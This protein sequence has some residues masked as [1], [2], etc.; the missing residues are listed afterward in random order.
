MIQYSIC[1]YRSN[2][3]SMYGIRII[4]SNYTDNFRIAIMPRAPRLSPQE[5]TIVDE[6]LARGERIAAILR[7]LNKG[8]SGRGGRGRALIAK[9]RDNRDEYRQ[10]LGP[11]SGGQRLASGP[12]RRGPAKTILACQSGTEGEDGAMAAFARSNG[13]EF[14]IYSPPFESCQCEAGAKGVKTCQTSVCENFLEGRKCELNCCTRLCENGATMSFLGPQLG[15]G[16]DRQFGKTLQAME[17]IS[18]GKLLGYY[19]GDLKRITQDALKSYDGEYLMLVCAANKMPD[20]NNGALYLDAKQRGSLM[21]FASHS[22]V[23]NAISHVIETENVVA[24]YANEYI[25]VGTLIT[26]DYGWDAMRCLCG[27][28]LCRYSP[29]TRHPRKLLHGGT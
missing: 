13:I 17:N 24:F 7:V 22:C 5:M 18:A 1:N 8:I 14:V 29:T 27:H 12:G 9:Y 11:E 4:W 20:L 19:T 21:R 3:A 26:L 6:M 10:S 23:P 28:R 2:F 25:P 16:T 15:V